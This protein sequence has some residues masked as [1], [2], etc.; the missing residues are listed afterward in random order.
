MPKVEKNK[1]CIIIP[2]SQDYLVEVDRFLETRLKKAGMKERDLADVAISVSEAVNNAIFHGNKCD[3]EKK[4]TVRV[5]V[6]S[7]TVEVQVEDQGEGFD[8]SKI[9][10]PVEGDNLLRKVGRGIFII[11]SLMDR[12]DFSFGSEGG[13][14]LKMYK[15][16]KTTGRKSSPEAGLPVAE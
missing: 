5:K 13:T 4:I 9:P 10:N 15:Q 1:N 6:T 7:G 3:L 8:P 12:V 2:S 16:F 11:R 14:V